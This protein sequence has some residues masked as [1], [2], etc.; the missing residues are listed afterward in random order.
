MPTKRSF[1]DTNVWLYA[2]IRSGEPLKTEIARQLI[3]SETIVTSSQV[4]NEICVNLLK[5]TD[6]REDNISRIITSF[7]NRYH[8]VEF[9]ADILLGA[10]AL[11]SKYNF[12]FWDSL[13]VSSA[14]HS[15]A[16]LL[17]TEDMHNGLLVENTLRIVSPFSS[18]NKNRPNE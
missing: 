2:L 14:L 7:Y 16:E 13:I 8:V 1:L 4:I 18:S 12:S 6:L 11:R 17:Y 3:Q 9:S 15:K 5:K 10:S